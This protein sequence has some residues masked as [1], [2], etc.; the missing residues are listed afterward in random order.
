MPAADEIVLGLNA[1]SAENTGTTAA[2]VWDTVENIRDETINLEK[3]FSD[4]TTR[5]ANGWRM[6][7]G[8]LKDASIDLQMVYKAQGADVERFRAAYFDNSRILMGFFDDAPDAAGVI[9]A[10][11][12]GGFEVTNFNMPRN[13]EEA[14]MIDVTLTARDDDAGG[15]PQWFTIDN[16]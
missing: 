6:Q 11:L 10:G 16:S 5:A 15:P 1:V 8:T 14:A 3:A 4:V 2:P 13:L 7:V 9:V 12:I